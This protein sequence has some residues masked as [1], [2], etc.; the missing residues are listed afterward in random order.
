MYVSIPQYISF[1]D[2]GI[3]FISELG[4]GSPYFV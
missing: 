3:S 1:H 2:K 4:R